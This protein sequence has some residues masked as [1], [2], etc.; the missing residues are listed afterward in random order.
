MLADPRTR[1]R[2]DEEPGARLSRRLMTRAEM[3]IVPEVR[4]GYYV[5][6]QDRPAFETDLTP[7]QLDSVFDQLYE[8]DKR[9]REESNGQQ[10]A[11]NG[12]AKNDAQ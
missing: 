11:Q 5:S 2:G 9:W 4:A 10:S 3:G 8:D 1:S 6:T 12:P 7:E